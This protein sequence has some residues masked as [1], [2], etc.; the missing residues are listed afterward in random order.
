MLTD[1][2][3]EVFRLQGIDLDAQL[4]ATDLRSYLVSG[5]LADFR[6]KSSGFSRNRSTMSSNSLDCP[7]CSRLWTASTRIS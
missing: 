7:V 2:R 6:Q 3:S 5:D 1:F 4:Q